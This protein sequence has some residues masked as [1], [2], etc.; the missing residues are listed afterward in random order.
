MTEDRR[1]AIVGL[2]SV[3]LPLATAFVE[4]GTEV[5]GWQ[6]QTGVDDGLRRTYE[7]ASGA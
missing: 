6:A 5:L 3:G 1:I 2:G 7:W 4:A